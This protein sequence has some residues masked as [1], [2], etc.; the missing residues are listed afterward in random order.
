L[1][2]FLLLLFK[3]TKCGNFAVKYPKTTRPILYILFL[4]TS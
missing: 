3:G 2:S 4:W 1:L